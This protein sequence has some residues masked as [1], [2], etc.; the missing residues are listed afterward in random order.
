MQTHLINVNALWCDIYRYRPISSCGCPWCSIVC[1]CLNSEYH[2]KRFTSVNCYFACEVYFIIGD[3]FSYWRPFNV[4][5]LRNHFVLKNTLFA[6]FPECKLDPRGH[7]YKGHIDKTKS[8]RTCQHWDTLPYDTIL[9]LMNPKPNQNG[10]K[11]GKDP[12]GNKGSTKDPV[13]LD[14]E[15]NYCRGYSH[16]S[17]ST[18]GPWCYV[19]GAEDEW[20]ECDVPLC[21]R[22]LYLTVH[23]Y[24]YCVLKFQNKVQM[25][26]ISRCSCYNYYDASN[27]N[28]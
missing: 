22:K 24:V 13:V 14:L 25:Q 4:K 2:V 28:Y 17:A 6:E 21:K 16:P 7:E 3:L 1:R 10:K 23:I 26:Q 20:E 5:S 11:T 8:G 18:Q 19:E 27:H 15:E 12:G 9:S